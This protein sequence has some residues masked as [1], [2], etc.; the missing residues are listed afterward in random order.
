MNKLETMKAMLAALREET[1]ASRVEEPR[2]VTAYRNAVETRLRHIED[3][4]AS[5]M[6]PLA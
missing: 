6:M 2:E 5:Q 1:A 4:L 3:M